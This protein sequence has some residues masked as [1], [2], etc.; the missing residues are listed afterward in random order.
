MLEQFF[1]DTKDLS[2]VNKNT[3]Q[4]LCVPNITSQNNLDKDSY[5]LVMHN[6]IKELNKIRDDLFF[7]LPITK[8]CKQLDFDNTKQYIFKMPSFPNSMR[9]HYDFYQWNEVLNAKKIEMDII[10]S[11]L[12]E[13]TTNIKNH[14][15]NTYSQDIPVI[16]YSHWIENSEFAPNWKTTFYHNNIT[17]MLQ[18][19]KCGLNTQTQIDALLEEATEYYS[20]KT[21]DKLRNIMTPLY[22]GIETNKINEFPS[23][24]TDKVIVFNHRTK[25][26]R[27][28]KHFIKIIQKLREQRQ[29]FKVFCSMIDPSG[30]QILKKTFDDISFFDF[31]G[32]DNRDEYIRKLENCRFGFHGG[33]R[34]AMSSQDGLCKG[35]PYVF[36]IG[37]ET[38]ELFGHKMETGFKTTDKAVELFNRMLDDNDWRN[39]Q[40]Q[41]AINHCGDVHSWGNRILPFNKMIDDAIDKQTSDMIQSGDKKDDIVDF[42]KTKRMVDTKTMSDYLGWGKQIGF[43]RY[44]NYVRSIDGI[45]TT[46]INKKEYYIYNKT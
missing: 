8:F 3:Y 38:G 35:V 40:S 27:G 1:E 28:W 46:V 33:S 17:G 39:K 2:S 13:Q 41:L 26:Y 10:W 25:E 29:D 6:V 9:A 16:G 14:C 34:W 4:I 15:H 32:P 45:Y 11:H 31:D 42:I 7:H 44:R 43:R 19:N 5:V 22:L 21:I 23:F 30:I 18:M 20:Q 37:N 36:E 24:K 12:P